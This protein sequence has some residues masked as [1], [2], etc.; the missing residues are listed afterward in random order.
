LVSLQSLAGLKAFPFSLSG[1][2]RRPDDP[3]PAL[4]GLLASVPTATTSIA[5]EIKN[6]TVSQQRKEKF[7]AWVHGH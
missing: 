1:F 3:M 5:A 4:A 6:T 7:T 2:Q